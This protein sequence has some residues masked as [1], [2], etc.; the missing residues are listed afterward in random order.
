M[1]KEMRRMLHARRFV[2]F[3][4]LALVL[5]AAVT[6]AAS[7]LFY[8]ILVPLWL[9][10]AFILAVPLRRE[11]EVSKPLLFPFLSFLPS[12]APPIA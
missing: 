11:A 5:L 4:C 8:A 7:G 3:L 12:R 6:P 9:F 10:V 1:I 2:V